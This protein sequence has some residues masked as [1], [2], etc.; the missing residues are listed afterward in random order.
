MFDKLG[1]EC[2][3]LQEYLRNSDEVEERMNLEESLLNYYLGGFTKPQ[4]RKIEKFL[5]VFKTK[6]EIVFDKNTIDEELMK[7]LVNKEIL[8]YDPGNRLIRPQSHL[9]LNVLRRVL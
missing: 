7:E 9:M 3:Y 5:S 8:F 6:E 1:G 4:M 2:W